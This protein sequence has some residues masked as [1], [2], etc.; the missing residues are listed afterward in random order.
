[1]QRVQNMINA[2]Y[3]NDT[4][5]GQVGAETAADE[6]ARLSNNLTTFP[7]CVNE[8][9]ERLI[10]EEM[11]VGLPE[12]DIDDLKRKHDN[13]C[14]EA[15]EAARK[16]IIAIET[17]SGMTH[18][19]HLF[20]KEETEELTD[21]KV[22]E[23]IVKVII[24]MYGEEQIPTWDYINDLKDERQRLDNSLLSLDYDE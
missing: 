15:L 13:K 12:D 7:R 9:V 1:M 14:N 20:T 19:P 11:S 2:Y 17:Y 5:F 3:E 10:V 23:L 16:A 21:E 6:V 22:L 8:Y 4:S 18:V 24:D